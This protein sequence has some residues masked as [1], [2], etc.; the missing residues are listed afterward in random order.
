MLRIPALERAL[1]DNPFYRI[2]PYRRTS[3]Y[4]WTFGISV[5]L[6]GSYYLTALL[7]LTLGTGLALSPMVGP[8]SDL[9]LKMLSYL[10]P[11]ALAATALSTERER[12]TLESLIVT[13]YPRRDM[14][15]GL[16]AARLE[17]VI[18]VLVFA[19]P[20]ILLLAAFGAHA[21]S[22]TGVRFP[23]AAGLGIG[24]GLLV[25]VGQVIGLAGNLA[26]ATMTGLWAAGRS[27]STGGAVALAYC[28]LVFAR[29]MLGCVAV[30]GVIPM[31]MMA[32]LGG[33]AIG[34]LV[35]ITINAAID[36]G[37]AWLLYRDAVSGLHTGSLAA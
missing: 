12:G 7:L 32:N 21:R 28:L 29:P 27:A 10:V 31:V 26:L 5:F 13:P 3:S 24:L 35:A 23:G 6:V 33:Q 25:G 4:R 37:F 14:L 19:V 20:G 17:P 2:A 1:G 15:L 8:V 11:P 18:R 22:F 34:E 16:V 36:L 30:V 9:F